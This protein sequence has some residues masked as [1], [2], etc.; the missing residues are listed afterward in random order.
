MEETVKKL[1]ITG[2]QSYELRIFNE[3]DPKLQVIKK[4]LKNEIK[5]YVE[6][7]LEWV[8]VAGG[9]G[10]ELWAGEV[11]AELKPTYPELKLA[12]IL[13]FA[14]YGNQWNEKNQ[15]LLTEVKT[16]AD[17]CDS[18]SHEPYKNP[19]QFK[20]LTTFLLAHTDGALI[21][22]DEEFPGKPKY[23][24]SAAR[25]V[26]ETKPYSIQSITMDDLENAIFDDSV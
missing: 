19:G 4:V 10:I 12:L 3:K 16:Q 14:D 2:Y 20:N 25:K 15:L 24:L 23:F 18:V 22:Y 21:V 17:F 13:P 7:G 9:L 26:Q 8:M 11:V 6:N 1:Y 5:N